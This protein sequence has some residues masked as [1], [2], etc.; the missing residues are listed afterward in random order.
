[1]RVLF[2][3]CSNA[4][5]VTIVYLELVLICTESFMQNRIARIGNPKDLALEIGGGYSL[6]PT[7]AYAE[8]LGFF[9]TEPNCFLLVH[10]E[11]TERE[12]VIDG[13][14]LGDGHRS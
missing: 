12:H 5:F 10:E 11:P 6:T 7:A 8:W 2:H 4:H 13:G 1:M 3:F 9:Q 14:E